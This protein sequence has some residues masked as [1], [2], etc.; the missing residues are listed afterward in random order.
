[1]LGDALPAITRGRALLRLAGHGS[2]P[3]AQS[4]PTRHGQRHSRR[5]HVGRF[6][7]LAVAAAASIGRFCV[8]A[9]HAALVNY[10][11][12]D[13]HRRHC[14][15]SAHADFRRPV[16]RLATRRA[17][18][19][20]SPSRP[21]R[22]AELDNAALGVACEMG[23]A[24]DA[25]SP[26]RRNPS[27]ALNSLPVYG[28]KSCEYQIIAFSRYTVKPFLAAPRHPHSRGSANSPRDCR[29][30]AGTSRQQRQMPA[31]DC[32]TRGLRGRR[33]RT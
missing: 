20:A 1:M 26:E 29:N 17:S 32:P 25:A 31:L 19:V 22:S 27:A 33:P 30:L 12:T 21:A 2:C 16:T 6:A 4:G 24:I 28:R 8:S 7:M 10:F 5:F 3:N 18:E 23:S 11:S 13:R 9:F 14:W 15:P